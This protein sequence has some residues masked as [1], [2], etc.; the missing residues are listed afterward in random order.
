METSIVIVEN[1]DKAIFLADINANI[2][3]II[4]IIAP[5]PANNLT[6]PGLEQ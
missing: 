4:R 6:K 5:I 2:A 3:K 1:T